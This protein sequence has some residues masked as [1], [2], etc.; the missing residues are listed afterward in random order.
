M[1]RIPPENL[2]GSLLDKVIEL[3]VPDK[4][5]KPLATP[6]IRAVDLLTDDN[7]NNDAGVCGQLGSF[8]TRVNIREMKGQ[9]SPADAEDLRQLAEATQLALGCG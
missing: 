6:L 8:I 7:P 3:D 9:L 5:R 1:D 4:V 2:V